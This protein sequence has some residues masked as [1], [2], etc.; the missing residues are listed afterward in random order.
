ML[1]AGFEVFTLLALWIFVWSSTFILIV[2]LEFRREAQIWPLIW[3]DK[4]AE[5][6]ASIMT[7]RSGKHIWE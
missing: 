5:I 1:A 7:I 2:V 4:R 3:L 6:F